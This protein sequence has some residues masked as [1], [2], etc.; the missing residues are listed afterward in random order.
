MF[1]TIAGGVTVGVIFGL[2]G[3]AVIGGI[4]TALTR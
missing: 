3:F 1:W 4:I 2:F